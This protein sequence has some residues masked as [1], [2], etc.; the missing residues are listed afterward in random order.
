VSR[1]KG[2]ALALLDGKT[3]EA[4]APQMTAV[5]AAGAGDSMTAALAYGRAKTARCA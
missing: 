5:E 4:R 3:L 1:A 2:G